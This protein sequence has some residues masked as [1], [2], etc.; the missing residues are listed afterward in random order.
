MR[1]PDSAF[2]FMDKIDGQ[3]LDIH[4]W[5]SLDDSARD[6]IVAQLHGYVSQLRSIIPLPGNIM[7]LPLANLSQMID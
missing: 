3:S 4:T 7:V 6:R 1:Y 2:I 5:L